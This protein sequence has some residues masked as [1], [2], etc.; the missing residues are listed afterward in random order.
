MAP[1]LYM[2]I[3]AS[4]PA[5]CSP[6]LTPLPTSPNSRSHTTNGDSPCAF[7]L[8]LLALALA[9]AAHA[10][11]LSVYATYSPTRF[12]NV[13]TGTTLNPQG[14]TYSYASPWTNIIGGG[15]T[16]GLLPIGP[17]HIG[18]D[19]RGSSHPNT[20]GSDTAM[21]GIRIGF[22]PPLLLIKL[23][24]QA[25]G[26]FV[27]T[28]SYNVGTGALVN[29]TFNNHY[30]AYEIIGGVDHKLLP[31][32][33]LRIIEFGVG[34]RYNTGISFSKSQPNINILTLNSGMVLH[35]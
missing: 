10:Q 18:L 22:K 30:A 6:W 24:V 26:G 4:A 27:A 7:C 13:L 21:A 31:I 23:Y 9:P 17:V 1:A 14:T 19:I 2:E 25:S 29:G 8:P 11:I 32:L 12:S 28:R 20:V 16:V 15:I 3:G 34:K 5:V 35:F 33:D